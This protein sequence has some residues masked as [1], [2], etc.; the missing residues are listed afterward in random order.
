M[1]IIPAI[2][3]IGGR[4]V[5]LVQGDYNRQTQYSASPSDM[6]R[7]YVEHG[8][9][10]IHVVDL[11]G[12]RASSPQNLAVLD[13][14]ANIPNA[15][16]E[17]GGGVKTERSLEQIFKHGAKYAVVG[18]AAVKH[19]ELFEQWLDHYGSDR[20]VL[21]ADVRGHKISI[22]GWLSDTDVTIEQLVTRFLSHGLTQVIC[23]DISC[24]GMLTGPNVDLYV[25]LQKS[26]PSV[27]FTVS[28]GIGSIEHIRRLRESG[29]RRAIIG[30]AIYENHINLSELC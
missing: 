3:I 7:L 30:K 4:C 12:A 24:D 29:L 26:F 2:D 10:R 19:P 9:R 20:L 27:T 28:G 5:R 23:T 21:G 1:L 6:V 14:I 15:D 16:I 25:R 11:D 13:Q 22:N 18:S 17:W 8:L